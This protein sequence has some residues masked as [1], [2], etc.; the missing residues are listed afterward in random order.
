MEQNIKKRD[1]LIKGINQTANTWIVSTKENG[2]FETPK[3]FNLEDGSPYELIAISGDTLTV[4]YSWDIIKE[5]H[6]GGNLLFQDNSEDFELLKS[7]KH[8]YGWK[9]A[10]NY[11]EVNEEDIKKFDNFVNSLTAPDE[12]EFQENIKLLPEACRYRLLVIAQQNID[13]LKKA[14]IEAMLLKIGQENDATTYHEDEAAK[15]QQKILY[16]LRK[17]GF[18]DENGEPLKVAIETVWSS[19]L[20]LRMYPWLPTKVTDCNFSLLIKNK[21]E[22]LKKQ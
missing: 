11:G 8:G 9:F 18:V 10:Y 6:I 7:I 12:N 14:N 1:Y 15:K 17:N 16:E 13:M 3:K 20:Q 19:F 4:T 2:I 21:I 5:M 22:Y